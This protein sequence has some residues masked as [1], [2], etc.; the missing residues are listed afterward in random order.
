MAAH[1]NHLKPRSSSVR[2]GENGLSCASGTKG[3]GVMGLGMT[4]CWHR[5]AELAMKAV[6]AGV[7]CWYPWVV[8]PLNALGMVFL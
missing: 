2:S 5:A 3:L 6:F 1:E 8:V 4:L 7:A